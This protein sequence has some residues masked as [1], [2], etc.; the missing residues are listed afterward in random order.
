MNS[1]LL[2]FPKVRSLACGGPSTPHMDLTNEMKHHR[3]RLGQKDVCLPDKDNQGPLAGAWYNLPH[4]SRLQ[5][6]QSREAEEQEEP[7]TSASQSVCL[8]LMPQDQFYFHLHISVNGFSE[9][10]W[11]RISDSQSLQ[12]N[13]IWSSS[14]KCL[15]SML[16]HQQPGQR[17][18]SYH[19]EHSLST[20]VE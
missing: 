13:R 2:I 16:C 4:M 5:C 12:C 6:R 1:M 17:E 15:E 20:K 9:P 10:D 7:Q 3:H 8:L 11:K 14:S 18:T 19:S